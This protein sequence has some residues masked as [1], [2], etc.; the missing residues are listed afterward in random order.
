MTLVAHEVSCAHVVVTL[1]RVEYVDSYATIAE[2]AQELRV[3][4]EHIRR[5]C[6]ADELPAVRVGS[7]WRIPRAGLQAYLTKSRKGADAAG[8]VA[9][10]GEDLVRKAC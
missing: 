9:G 3:S 10:S 8:G 2:V 4:G 7:V 5:F 6:D 1:A